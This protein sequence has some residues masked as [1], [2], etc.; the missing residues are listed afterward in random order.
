MQA[1]EADILPSGS[2]SGSGSVPAT[3]QPRAK[4][5]SGPGAGTG[6]GKGQTQKMGGMSSRPCVSSY[7]SSMANG[8]MDP[9]AGSSNVIMAPKMAVP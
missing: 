7:A 8:G 9:C 6:A 4:S 3:G 5:G 1:R 2:G